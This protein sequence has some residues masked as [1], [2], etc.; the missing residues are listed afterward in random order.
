VQVAGNYVVNT[1]ILFYYSLEALYD[2]ISCLV[3]NL[4]M[5]GYVNVI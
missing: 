4:N 2:G 1:D 3:R 5:E